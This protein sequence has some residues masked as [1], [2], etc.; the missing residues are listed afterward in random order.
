MDTVIL[1]W[2]AE[3]VVEIRLQYFSGA[4]PGGPLRYADVHTCVNNGFEIYP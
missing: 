4:T 3:S 2:R 1:L